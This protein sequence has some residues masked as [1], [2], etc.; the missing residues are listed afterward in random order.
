[1]QSIRSLIRSTGFILFL[2]LVFPTEGDT[3]KSMY[4][5]TQQDLSKFS[6]AMRNELAGL[7]YV[8]NPYQVRQFIS[9]ENDSLR[10]EWL[11]VFWKSQDPTPTTPYNEKRVEHNVRVRLAR[12]FFR[13]AKWPGWDKRGEVFIRYGPP[14]YRGKIWGE[15][16]AARVHPP[17]ELWFYK[18]HSMLVSF[19][20]FG[21]K[22]EYIYSINPM[23]SAQDVSPELI[24]F[25]VY[26]TDES[27]TS[28]IPQDLLEFYRST[29]NQEATEDSRQR[30]VLLDPQP[31]SVDPFNRARTRGVWESIDAFM[32]GLSP[33]APKDVSFVFQ[34]DKIEEYA[35]NFEKTLEEIPSSYPFNF[36]NKP[37]PFYFSVDQFKAGEALNRVEVNIEVVVSSDEDSSA[38]RDDKYTAEAV[39]WDSEYNE[40]DRVDRELVLRVETGTGQ[41]ERL[42]PTQ[43]V[44]SLKEGYY[45]MGISVEASETKRSS[46]YR[47][48]FSTERFV[49]KLAI[50]DI[51]FASRIAKLSEPSMWGR[52]ALEIVP[53][54]LHTYSKSFAIPVYFEVY[55]IGLDDRGVSSYTVEYKIIPHSNKKS[56]FWERFEKTPPVV[57]SSFRA[58]GYSPYETHHLHLRT[59]NLWEGSFD[60]LITVNDQ[61][62]SATVYRKATFSILE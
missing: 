32:G 27:L 17:G 57:S 1:M 26:D 19:Q 61:I 20:N 44:F 39:V 5:I 29:E 10:E 38:A 13:L 35:N 22:G 11:N 33:A 36:E 15:V 46:A 8:L 58:S 50:S 43:L 55:N 23:G 59:E 42:I 60:L 7:Q 37:V 49:E 41:W 40:I 54:P 3:K 21:L 31:G 14:D 16:T 24:E 12:Q 62:N 45:R 48:T 52:G 2:I 34:K 9:L 56:H 18:R 53:H 25:L 6:P 51:L 47:T 4:R 30:D 28:R